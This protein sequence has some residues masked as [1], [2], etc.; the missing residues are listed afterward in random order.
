MQAAMHTPRGQRSPN[1]TGSE[2]PGRKPPEMLLVSESGGLTGVCQG[3][4]LGK[5]ALGQ[6]E[7]CEWP[8]R[9][10]VETAGKKQSMPKHSL[11]H[12]HDIAAWSLN[13]G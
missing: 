11:C 13:I 2:R 5:L 7:L 1:R 8:C 9:E 3:W 6:S 4:M 10:W 12:E